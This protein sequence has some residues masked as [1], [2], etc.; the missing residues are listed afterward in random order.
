MTARKRF[1]GQT[2]IVT[3]AARGIGRAIAACMAREGAAL[4]LWDREEAVHAVARDFSETGVTASAWVVDVG[5]EQAVRQAMD[6]TVAALGGVHILVNNA[7]IVCPAPIEAVDETD[8]DQAV[9]VNLK[10]AFFCAR[11]CFAQMKDR[12]S[13]SIVNISSRASLGKQQRTVYSACKAGLI[14]MTRTWALEMAPYNVTVNSV[15]PGPIATRL[16]TEANPPDSPQTQAILSSV[17]L[18]RIG[19]P[20]DVAHAVAFLASDE[21]AFITGQTLFVCGGLTVGSVHQ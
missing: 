20:E 5:R 8:W 6:E 16:F 12:R 4:A 13:G 18:G 10:G 2:A 14:G 21:A 15:A 1:A 11:H 9:S 3:G 17:P 7:G 19:T